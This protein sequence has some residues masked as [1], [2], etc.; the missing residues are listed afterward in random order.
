MLVILYFKSKYG[1][2]S[3]QTIGAHCHPHI[4]GEKKTNPPFC[5]PCLSQKMVVTS[6]VRVHRGDEK[7]KDQ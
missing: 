1:S 3:Y 6:V 2:D 7:M 5:C 4:E